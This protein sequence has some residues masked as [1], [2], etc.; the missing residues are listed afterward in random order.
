MPSLSLRQ[1]HFYNNSKVQTLTL[2]MITSLYVHVG[3]IYFTRNIICNK[4]TEDN[5]A[6]EIK[7]YNVEMRSLYK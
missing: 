1:F 4:T 3:K 7:P 2:V 5:V 6:F